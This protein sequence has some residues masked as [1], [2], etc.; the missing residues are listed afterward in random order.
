MNIEA[1]AREIHNDV[2]AFPRSLALRRIESILL[3]HQTA[4]ESERPVPNSDQ[5]CVTPQTEVVE[6]LPCHSEKSSAIV[7]AAKAV[8]IETRSEG[9]SVTTPMD[10]KSSNADITSGHGRTSLERRTPNGDD[11][12]SAGDPTLLDGYG[13]A[14]QKASQ[15]PAGPLVV[16]QESELIES[17]LDRVGIPR[18]SESGNAFPLAGRVG[19]LTNRYEHCQSPAPA[20]PPEFPDGVSMIV[21][22]PGHDY[23][24]RSL[25]GGAPQRITFVKREGE[26]YPGNVGHY[27]GIVSQ[28]LM[29]IL[30]DRGRYVN[31]QIPCWETELA[32]QFIQAA[33]SLYECRA[34]RTH[35][36]FTEYPTVQEFF[37]Q[38]RC[39]KCGHVG[40]T[41]H[42]LPSPPAGDA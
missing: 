35:E 41:R 4:G 32:N 22:D 23:W 34:G 40:C 30:I 36:R 1:A 7:P 10:S 28:R 8:S 42:D 6:E 27:G 12:G 31:N 14:L 18:V 21:I 24:V 25:D 19:I 20:G 2:P 33:W 37:Q 39:D 17:H 15:A 29:E 11:A 13:W 5:S 9:S 26:H 38:P 16:Q 3:K